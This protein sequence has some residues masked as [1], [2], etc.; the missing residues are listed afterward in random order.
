MMNSKLYIEFSDHDIKLLEAKR[1]KKKLIV[2]RLRKENL[3]SSSE[4]D[5]QVA[6][7][8]LL[9]KKSRHKR[10]C[11]ILVSTSNILTKT[12]E[13]P[14]LKT[15]DIQSL[16]ENNLP[17]Y[18]AVEGNEYLISFKIIKEF[19]KETEEMKKLF[20]KLLL[21]AYPKDMFQEMLELCQSFNLRPTNVDVYPN[22]L[23]D[24]F[25][26]YKEPIS[27]IDVQENGANCLIL[28]EQ[29]LFLYALFNPNE[30][31]D[32][33]SI[34]EENPLES[35]TNTI[36]GYLNFYSTKNFGEKV[37]QIFL[38]TDSEKEDLKDFLQPY[39]DGY[40]QFNSL[41]FNVEFKK[42]KRGPF[43]NHDFLSIFSFA[44]KE[45]K[46]QDINLMTKF[47]MIEKNKSKKK[48]LMIVGAAVA[49]AGMLYTIGEPYYQ[50]I[51]VKKDIT[52]FEENLGQADEISTKYNEFESLSNMRREKEKL[53]VSLKQSQYDYSTLLSIVYSTLPEGVTIEQ[54]LVKDKGLV[55][56]SFRIPNTL[57][58]SELVSNINQ[59]QYFDKVF[60]ESI[61][62]NDRPESVVLNLTI[63]EEK[64]EIFLLKGES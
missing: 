22:V 21:V 12:I 38:F 43:Q 51:V 47:S 1:S 50:K 56:V 41:P 35:I 17:Q 59:L 54:F 61:S 8:K 11:S 10:D 62:L 2:S 58:A 36:S 25:S 29:D 48:T 4:E 16:L 40:V 9:G 14:K 19:E 3:V 33:F 7:K 44:M 31:E 34:G 26:T 37:K 13:V 18:F 45:K 23:F 5:K 53:L 27:I 20:L 30:T 63:L 28:N 57:Q 24:R 42:K 55:Q 32:F 15:K 52:A 46:K 39:I 6:F 49:M 60:L 64:K